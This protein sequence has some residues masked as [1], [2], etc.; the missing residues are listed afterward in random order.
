MIAMLIEW[1]CD[2]KRLPSMVHEAGDSLGID[3]RHEENH[4]A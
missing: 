2:T 3:A 4:S 1:R